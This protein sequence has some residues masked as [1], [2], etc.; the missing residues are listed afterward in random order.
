MLRGSP[1]GNMHFH[2]Q[3]MMTKAWPKATQQSSE[4]SQSVFFD[5]PVPA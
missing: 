2:C 5:L 4:V 1:W 3:E